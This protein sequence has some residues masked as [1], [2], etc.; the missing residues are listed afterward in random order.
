MTH[1][2]SRVARST[3]F[4]VAAEVLARGANTIFF[5]LLTWYVSEA[6]AGRYNLG[7]AFALLLVPFALGGFDQLL[8]REAACNRELAPRLL[9]MLLI[10]RGLGATLCYTGLLLWLAVNGYDPQTNVVVAVLAATCIP[11]SMINLYQGYLFVFERVNYI[12][13]IGMVSGALKLAAGLTILAFGG[14][15]LGAA[16]TVLAASL[17]SLTLYGWVV[18]TRC[19]PPHWRLDLNLLRTYFR[20]ALT[21]YLLAVFMMLEGVQDTLLLSR[22]HGPQAVAAYGA[23]TNIIVALNILPHSFRQAVLPIM[24]R[25]YTNA[26]DQVIHIVAHSLRLLLTGTLLISLSLTIMI[27]PILSTLYRGHYANAASVFVTLVCAFVFSSCAIPNA[28]LIIVSGQQGIFVPLHLVSMLLN[29]A[30]N[31]VLQPYFGAQ[32]A[33]F[34]RLASAGLV[35]LFVTVYVQWRVQRWP[36]LSVVQGPIVACAVA[37]SIMVVLQHLHVA[38]PVVLVGSWLTYGLGLW[39]LRVLNTQDMRQ[40]VRFF[41]PVRRSVD[42]S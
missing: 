36:I 42:L 16:V 3:A 32:G 11:E 40:L 38:L 18:A 28:R 7:F 41:R 13:L 26:R 37:F 22:T 6:D 33:A 27:E 24:A 21:F 30:L 15:A 17:L 10:A 31:L 35:C 25:L 1:W 8:I 9:G 2:A 12:T 14:T 19:V 20:P 34:S 39:A 29:L 23:A 5:I 4:S